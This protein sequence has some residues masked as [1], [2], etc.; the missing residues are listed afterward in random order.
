MAYHTSIF[1]LTSELTLAKRVACNHRESVLLLNLVKLSAGLGVLI[2]MI[3]HELQCSQRQESL[4]LL[5]P[6]RYL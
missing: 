4:I 1:V 3:K 2:R 6:I 5:D